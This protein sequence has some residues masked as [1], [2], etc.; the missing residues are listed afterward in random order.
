MLLDI[1][2]SKTNEELSTDVGTMKELLEKHL[3]RILIP[4]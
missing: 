4:V 1:F 2:T 3:N